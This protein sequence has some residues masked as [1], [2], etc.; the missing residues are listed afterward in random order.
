MTAEMDHVGL[1]QEEQSL[2][3][4]R[5]YRKLDYDLKRVGAVRRFEFLPNVTNLGIQSQTCRVA[6]VGAEE[7]D[8]G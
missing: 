6:A 7:K 5:T 2:Q 1:V 8:L 3:I 4:R